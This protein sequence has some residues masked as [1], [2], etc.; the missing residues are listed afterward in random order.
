ME[1][2]AIERVKDLA[3][4]SLA[5]LVA[6]SERAGFRFVRKLVD[7]WNTGSNC[8][9]KPGEALFTAS[10]DGR[11]VGVGG[12]NQDPYAGAPGIGRVR[13]LYVLESVRRRGV[14][15]KLVEAIVVQA[16]DHFELLRLR[17]N[18]ETGGQFYLA[19]G[20]KHCAS[21]SHSTHELRLT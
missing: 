18:T 5:E 6:E 1:A 8:F 3:P 19:M 21:E 14:A 20:F 17:T 16:R 9:D 4:D 12:L 7:E 13:R 15:R 11:V 2:I 10:V